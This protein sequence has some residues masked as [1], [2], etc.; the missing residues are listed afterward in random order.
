MLV[1][2]VDAAGRVDGSPAFATWRVD[3]AAPTVAFDAPEDGATVRDLTPVAQGTTGDAVGDALTVDVRVLDE[4]GDVVRHVTGGAH[5]GRWSAEVTPALT[6]GW[7]R[8]R[9]SQA[10]D[11][12]HVGSAEVAVVVDD[13]PAPPETTISSAPAALTAA[14]NATFTF[15]A[16]RPDAK[17]RCRVD[18]GAWEA[19][20][21][22][23][24][25]RSLGDGEHA[26]EVRASRVWALAQQRAWL[27]AHEDPF[28]ADSVARVVARHDEVTDHDLAAGVPDGQGVLQVRLILVPGLGEEGVRALVTAIAE[29]LATDGELRARV[30]GLSF[31]VV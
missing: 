15:A 9:V 31:T 10:D 14:R 28:V 5:E 12:G 26:F 8:L 25:V 27:P 20:T 2:A 29:A 6:P 30:D 4:D 11:A 18:A 17:L 3:A 19:C 21:S 24:T 16:D 1:R 22:P 13:R 23:W 7:Y